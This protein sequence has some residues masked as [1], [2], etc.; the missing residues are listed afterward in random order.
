MGARCALRLSLTVTERFHKGK[1]LGRKIIVVGRVATILG[2]G[3]TRHIILPLNRAGKRLLAAARR[4]VTA[5][6][7][8][9]E[10][11]PT[12]STRSVTL[13]DASAL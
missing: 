6:L 4:S 2:A 7:T 10:E 12:V 13:S 11:A 9:T 1:R 5:R 3:Q 8:V